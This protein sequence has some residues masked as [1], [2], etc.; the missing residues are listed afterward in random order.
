[1]HPLT[2]FPIFAFVFGTMVGS[3]LN[4]V[5]G[6]LPEGR[7]VAYPGSHCPH[8]GNPVRPYDNV[9]VL[10]WFWLRGRCRDC[11]SPI[12]SLYP[13]VELMM[14]CVALLLYQQIFTTTLDFTVGNL[15]GFVLYFA[16]ISALVAES[17]IDVKYYIIPDSLSIYAAPFALGGMWLLEWLGSDVGIGWEMSV[18]GAF[19]GGGTLAAVAGLWWL[20]R[21]YEGMGWGDVKLLL[22]IGAMV[23]PW[24]ALPFIFLVSA[25]LAVMI[26]IPVGILQGKGWKM[27]LPFGPF[28]ALATI[29]WLFHAPEIVS[30]W[31]PGVQVQFY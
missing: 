10:A 15:F 4:V 18:L 31:L 21:R 9:P 24:P 17:F 22:L 13:T 20:I 28:L 5:I 7:S 26:G 3:F 25:C 29:I 1:M 23:G 27:A 30:M 8:C 6:R 16:F 2:V 11:D 12:S 19:F 14:G